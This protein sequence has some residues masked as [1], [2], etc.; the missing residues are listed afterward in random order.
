MKKKEDPKTADAL[1]GDQMDLLIQTISNEETKEF[2]K[3]AIQM[4]FNARFQRDSQHGPQIPFPQ[5]HSQI[6]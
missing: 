6:N 2:L 3:L 1:W 5:V 4:I